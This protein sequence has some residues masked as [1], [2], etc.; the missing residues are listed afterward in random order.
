MDPQL[1]TAPLDRLLAAFNDGDLNG[2]RA[3]LAEDAVAY[4]TT[5]GGGEVRIDGAGGY[6]AAV[7]AWICR[8]LRTRSP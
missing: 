2:M 8:R 1:I 7:E 6:V 3:V 4:V 5:G